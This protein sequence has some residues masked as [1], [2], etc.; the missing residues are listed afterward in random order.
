M[1]LDFAFDSQVSLKFSLPAWTG[2]GPARVEVGDD[3]LVL[4]ETIH[5]QG[6]TVVGRDALKTAPRGYP[7]DH[8]RIELLR[9]KGLTASGGSRASASS[10]VITHS[11]PSRTN[12]TNAP[13]ARICM[14]AP[15]FMCL[16]AHLSI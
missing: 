16:S 9:Y 2:L 10:G 7:R 14:Y 4:T 5:A 13:C 15:I 12:T 1:N 3:I 11:S 8:P 6:P